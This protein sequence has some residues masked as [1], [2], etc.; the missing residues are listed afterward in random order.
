MSG[1]IRDPSRAEPGGFNKRQTHLAY[2]ARHTYGR[3]TRDATRSRVSV[4]PLNGHELDPGPM[5]PLSSG[6]PVRWHRMLLTGDLPRL[7]SRVWARALPERSSQLEGDCRSSG[8]G[9]ISLERMM[10]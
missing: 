9:F 4:G 5:V 7:R 1:S 8:S 3:G 6:W 2:A 10:V